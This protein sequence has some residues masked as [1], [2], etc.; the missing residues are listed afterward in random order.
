LFQRSAGTGT[1]VTSAAQTFPAGAA[2]T[3][4]L[5]WTPSTI[6]ISVNGGS[7]S[8]A[9]TDI[10]SLTVGTFYIASSSIGFPLDGDMQWLA[11][12]TGTLTASD[13]ATINGWGSNDP[14]RAS[15]PAAA[16]TTMTWDG[17]SSSGS[18]K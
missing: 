15:F 7:T 17:T 18:L 3:I 14:T 10:P 13:F 2:Q 8:V 9:D 4:I 1:S 12:G 11:T 5:A 6:T 16:Q